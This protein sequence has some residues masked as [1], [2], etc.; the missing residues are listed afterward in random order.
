MDECCSKHLKNV[1]LCLVRNLVPPLLQNGSRSQENLF[2]AC[3]WVAVGFII[4]ELG[5]LKIEH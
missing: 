4:A 5:I 2:A 3:H 1:V